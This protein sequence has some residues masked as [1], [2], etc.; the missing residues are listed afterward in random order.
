MQHLTQEPVNLFSHTA[1][2]GVVIW[3]CLWHPSE[4]QGTCNRT[5]NN[6]VHGYWTVKVGFYIQDYYA[7]KGFNC[8]NSKYKF[9]F[10]FWSFSTNSRL[11][12][13]Q[14]VSL[15]KSL[16]YPLTQF[17]L[18]EHIAITVGLKEQVNEFTSKLKWDGLRDLSDPRMTGVG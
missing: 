5:E 18:N 10:Y 12:I 13:M 4:E 3:A 7:E 1:I 9:Q 11:E 6:R 17:R 16:N 14:M 8:Q 15:S 2:P